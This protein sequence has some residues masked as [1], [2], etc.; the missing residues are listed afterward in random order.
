MTSSGPVLGEEQA[1]RKQERLVQ[2]NGSSIDYR[3]GVADDAWQTL[4]HYHED[5]P[6]YPSRNFAVSKK[7][8]SD[9]DLCSRCASLSER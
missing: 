8:P 1:R 7:K 5:C 2:G 4:W 6:R 9:D 3:R